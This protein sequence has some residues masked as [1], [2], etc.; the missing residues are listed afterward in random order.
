MLRLPLCRALLA[1][2]KGRYLKA[3]TPSPLNARALETIGSDENL[4]KKY[5]ACASAVDPKEEIIDLVVETEKKDAHP[6]EKR[7]LKEELSLLE[8]NDVVLP[9]SGGGQA[10][11]RPAFW[12]CDLFDPGENPEEFDEQVADW[13]KDWMLDADGSFIPKSE[14]A[15]RLS[16]AEHRTDADAD[17]VD[18]ERLQATVSMSLNFLRKVKKGRKVNDGEVSDKELAEVAKAEAEFKK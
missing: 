9:I 10:T 17:L 8:V 13:E 1:P 16:T 15:K 6:K 3:I 11:A 12:K 5:E 7:S 4:R 2:G 18:T 14:T